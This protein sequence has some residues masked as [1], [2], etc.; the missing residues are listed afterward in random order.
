MHICSRVKD[1]HAFCCWPPASCHSCTL[2][3]GQSA[4]DFGVVPDHDVRT[5]GRAT[6]IALRPSRPTRV[7]MSA[8]SGPASSPAGALQPRA[9]HP[10]CGHTRHG[11]SCGNSNG[12]CEITSQFFPCWFYFVRLIMCLGRNEPLRGSPVAPGACAPFPTF[13]GGGRG[14]PAWHAVIQTLQLRHCVA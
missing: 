12:T 10:G 14:V 5:V 8:A 3:L 2:T 9:P 6:P 7:A 13:V 11:C 4:H 1:H